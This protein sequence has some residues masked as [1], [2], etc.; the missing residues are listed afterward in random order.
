L[1]ELARFVEKLKQEA[2][3]A[4]KKIVGVLASKAAE[5]ERH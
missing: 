4:R 1:T 2:L 3:E 5:Q